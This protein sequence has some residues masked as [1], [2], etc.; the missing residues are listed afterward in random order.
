MLAFNGALNILCH[1]YGA[2]LSLILGKINFKKI[3]C[4][5][6]GLRLFFTSLLFFA[7]FFCQVFVSIMFSCVCHTL[8]LLA[9]FLTGLP[10]F[11]IGP[12]FFLRLP[13]WRSFFQSGCTC[14]DPCQG[15]MWLVL[16]AT[17][18]R[19]ACGALG[20]ARSWTD[21]PGVTKTGAT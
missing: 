18:V 11:L 20:L 7:I 9:N 21:F 2:F 1:I 10:A 13:R 17:V 3:F 16:L 14:S 5:V 6:F 4:C 8:I 15:R 12:F 19:F